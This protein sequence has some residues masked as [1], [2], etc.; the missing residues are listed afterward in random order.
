MR[1]EG[2]NARQSYFAAENN[3]YFSVGSLEGA[4]FLKTGLLV[5]LSEQQIVDCA[6]VF[7][8]QNIS[9]H[10]IYLF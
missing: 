9:F 1:L 6:W 5:S 8:L 2:T 3:F 4:Y 10:C 7:I